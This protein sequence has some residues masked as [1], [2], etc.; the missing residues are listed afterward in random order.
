V[1]YACPCFW[2]VVQLNTYYRKR[3]VLSAS[4][5]IEAAT[6]GKL[7]PTNH[8]LSYDTASL[9]K[10]YALLY[11]D[12]AQEVSV[13]RPEEFNDWIRRVADNPPL[14]ESELTRTVRDLRRI[15]RTSQAMPDIELPEEAG[16]D[17][18]PATERPLVALSRL[19]RNAFDSELILIESSVAVPAPENP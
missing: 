18:G 13:Q 19:A 2:T 17:E 7:S 5:F 12:N 15:A 11:S 1:F 6:I 8:H 9:N 14:T 10:G 4:C 3:S 16:S